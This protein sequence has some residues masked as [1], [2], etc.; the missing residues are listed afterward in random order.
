VTSTAADTAT[1]I[2]A[3]VSEYRRID[4]ALRAVAAFL[5]THPAL[6]EPENVQVRVTPGTGRA[7][8]QVV[9]P[10]GADM[11][12]SEH[13]LTAWAKALGGERAVAT[14]HPEGV[15]PWTH[16]CAEGTLGALKVRVVIVHIHPA[17]R[18]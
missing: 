12:V 17:A 6:P 5:A 1:D 15:E 2:D 10:Q 4:P 13:A 3:P 8:V 18:A 14:N 16:Y 9:L 11:F 7:R